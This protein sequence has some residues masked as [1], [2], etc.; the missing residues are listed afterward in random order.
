[1][2][3]FSPSGWASQAGENGKLNIVPLLMDKATFQSVFCSETPKITK[4][5]VEM[6]APG[7]DLFVVKV[8]CLN[9][10]K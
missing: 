10:L 3:G 9:H 7:D 5:N 4:M 8:R 6:G 1:M 2:D